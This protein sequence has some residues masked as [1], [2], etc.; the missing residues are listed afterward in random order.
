VGVNP[1]PLHTLETIT[2]FT[3]N[4]SLNQKIA[5]PPCHQDYVIFTSIQPYFQKSEASLELSKMAKQT[6]EKGFETASQE[7]AEDE[8]LCHTRINQL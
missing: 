4:S 3:K 5:S 8:Y 6:R 1:L 7:V 2:P